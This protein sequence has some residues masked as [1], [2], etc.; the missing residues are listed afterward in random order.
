[1]NR[2]AV[3]AA[4]ARRPRLPAFHIEAGYYKP[5][6][7][8]GSTAAP[9]S[10]PPAPRF[11][12]SPAGAAEAG[13][14]LRACSGRHYC[15]HCCCWWWWQRPRRRRHRPLARCLLPRQATAA[16]AAPA[17]GGSPSPRCRRRR[18]PLQSAPRRPPTAPESAGRPA[19]PVRR[20]DWWVGCVG[21]GAQ[22]LWQHTEFCCSTNRAACLPGDQETSHPPTSHQLVVVGR[23]RR[24]PPKRLDRRQAG[25]HREP[26]RRVGGARPEE[27]PSEPQAVAMGRDGRR[28]GGVGGAGGPEEGAA[29]G[30][31]AGGV[32]GAEFKWWWWW[33]D[34]GSLQV[35]KSGGGDERVSRDLTHAAGSPARDRSPLTATCG[36]LRRSTGTQGRARPARA[37][38]PARGRRPPGLGCRPPCRGVGCGVQGGGGVKRAGVGRGDPHKC[39][40]TASPTHPS[41][42][43]SLATGITT[44]GN[45][46]T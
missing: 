46:M 12:A 35:E 17:A 4:A 32:E 14:P 33:R 40:P 15:C 31:A 37:A 2:T 42:A 16:A 30:G 7:R 11:G 45:E 25:R 6:P 26:R 43:H 13:R 8:C 34:T 41:I 20:V 27:L 38:R 22:T 36:R 21:G 5:A 39:R 19:R 3:T 29:L 44:G 24:Q 28:E 18:G 1:M 10:K 23:H 9:L